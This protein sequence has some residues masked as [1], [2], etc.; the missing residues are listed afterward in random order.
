MRGDLIDMATTPVL[1]AFLDGA[2]DFTESSSVFPS[3]TRVNA[4]A[5]G[6]G[7]TP[8]RSGIVANKFF[9]P[10]IAGGRL[11]NTG[12]RDEMV[13]AED[14]AGGRYV[15]GPTLGDVLADAGLT[16]AVVS[17][18]TAGTTHLVNPRARENR[19]IALCMRDWQASL[20]SD[21]AA[22][23][24][25]RFGPL[26]PAGRPNSARMAQMTTMFLEGVFPRV[27][28]DA[29]ILW[30]NDPDITFH[31]EGLGS[32][33][34]TAALAALDRE[35]ARLLDWAQSSAPGRAVQIVLASDHGHITARER[36]EAKEVLARSGLALGG[37]PRRDGLAGTLGYLGAI[38]AAAPDSAALHRLVGWMVAQ[39][40]CGPL[41]TAPRNDVEG[42]VLGTLSRSLLLNDH[43]R[44]PHLFCLMRADDRP[45]AAG[46]EGS[47]YFDG[48]MPVGGS[49]HGGLHR[50]EMNNLLALSGPAFQPARRYDHPAGIID[51]A[52]T[53]LAL[54]G[55]M[56]P[57]AMQ[58]RVLR[59]AFTGGTLPDSR[60]STVELAAPQGILRLERAQ[61]GATPYVLSGGVV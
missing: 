46:I 31:H 54:L 3:S 33:K 55:L 22:E 26:A 34:A 36:I 47:C 9:D 29:A 14:H 23:M 28:P 41:F 39:P 57:A 61:V 30:Y 38:R 12:N 32:P 25:E 45:N 51:I 49:I 8:S 6:S 4:C 44:S 1:R 19:Q 10:D 40:W 58:G 60:R 42:V 21:F 43:D 11:L 2:C 18:A 48:D 20:P 37:D 35:F 27:R 53:V 56:P 24:L 52:P 17:A 15:K 13:A 59:E 50:R 7:A 16:L 5:L